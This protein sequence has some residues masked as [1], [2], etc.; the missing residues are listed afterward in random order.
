MGEMTGF[1]GTRCKRCKKPLSNGKVLCTKCAVMIKI[2]HSDDIETKKNEYLLSKANPN[3][4]NQT[5]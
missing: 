3:N 4:A 5:K 1:M 2:E